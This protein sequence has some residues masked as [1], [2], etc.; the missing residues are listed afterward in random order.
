MNPQGKGGFQKG[1]SG[2]PKGRKPR[3]VEKSYLDRLRSRVS[4]EDWDAIID[5]AIR[6]AKKGDPTDRKFLADYI[7]GV[8]TQNINA[9]LTGDIIINWGDNVDSN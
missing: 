5:Q 4:R 1:V 6:G 3:E 9:K 8:P 2:N 7:I